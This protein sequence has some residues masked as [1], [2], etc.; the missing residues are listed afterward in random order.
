MP[1]VILCDYKIIMA[2]LKNCPLATSIQVK[3][4]FVLANK[5]TNPEWARQTVPPIRVVTS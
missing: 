5:V 3:A 4:M 2:D 1:N